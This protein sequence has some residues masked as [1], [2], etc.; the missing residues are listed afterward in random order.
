MYIL[1]IL[2]DLFP[3]QLNKRP[4]WAAV[5]AQALDGLSS[6]INRGDARS[7][8][9][10][11]VATENAISAVVKIIRNCC[12]GMDVSNVSEWI[13]MGGWWRERETSLFS[14]CRR[15]SIGCPSLKTTRNLFMSTVSWL[16][17][18]RYTTLHY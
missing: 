13:E 16:I 18:S 6:M 11:A 14:I 7:T 8:E 4:E 9:E 17:S 1:C 15:L 2:S 5:A 3:F 10:S 12:P